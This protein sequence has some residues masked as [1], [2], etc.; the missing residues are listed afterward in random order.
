[1]DACARASLRSRF[2]RVRPGKVG[3]AGMIWGMI[4]EKVDDATSIV[5][6]MR[7]LMP[8]GDGRDGRLRSIEAL[9]ATGSMFATIETS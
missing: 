7:S 4:P 9:S 8:L 3:G 6:A 5:P 2:P 1:L